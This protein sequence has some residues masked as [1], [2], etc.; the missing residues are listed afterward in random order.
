MADG[1]ELLGAPG[2]PTD[3]RCAFAGCGRVIAVGQHYI[4][5]HVLFDTAGMEAVTL[6]R[7]PDGP[8]W[9]DIFDH[10]ICAALA[11]AMAGLDDPLFTDVFDRG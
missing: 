6:L 3:K 10:P 4:R 9:T 5:A 7:L 11:L 2:T 8:M 1:E